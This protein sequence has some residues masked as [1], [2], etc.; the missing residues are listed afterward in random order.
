MDKYN[1]LATKRKQYNALRVMYMQAKTL[2]KK[3]CL[4]NKLK[5]LDDEIFNLEREVDDESE[6]TSKTN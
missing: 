6:Q 3:G 1:K 4:L 5:R 2:T